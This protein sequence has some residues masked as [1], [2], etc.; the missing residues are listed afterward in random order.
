MLAMTSVGGSGALPSVVAAGRAGVG[1]YTVARRRICAG[2]GAF[3]VLLCCSPLAMPLA[4]AEDAA[5]R[6]ADIEARF[7]AAD[8]NDDGKLTLDEARAGMPRAGR[9]ADVRSGPRS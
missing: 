3:G 6:D 4:F 2:P 5:K 1:V 8:K 9:R 7:K